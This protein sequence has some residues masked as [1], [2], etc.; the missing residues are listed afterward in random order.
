M[1]IG[2]VLGAGGVLGTA[3]LLGAL[4][5]V[6]AAT[7]WTPA[8]AE[9]VVGTSAGA[10]VGA[11]GATG[12]WPLPPGHSQ[13]ALLSSLEQASHY[14]LGAPR[15]PLIP[16]SARLLS[17]GWRAHPRSRSKLLAGILPQGLLLTQPVEAFISSLVPEGWP[18]RPRLWIV[19]TDYESGEPVVF[20]REDAPIVALP[21][22]VA[23]SCAMP[24]FFRP[25]HIEGRAYV[26]GAV[27]AGPGLGLLAGQGLDLA[28]CMNPGS[29]EIQGGSRLLRAVWH[30]VH[31][32]VAEQ[33]WTVEAKGTQVVIVEPSEAVVRRMGLNLM[34][35][36]GARQIGIQAA[37]DVERDVMAGPL[38]ASLSVNQGR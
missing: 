5:G 14:R 12:R 26:D 18:Q 19:A 32:Q 22:A 38:R 8:E 1:R 10:I 21:S 6:A 28:I 13:D 27:S 9:F 2:L 7:G 37:A 23:A 17:R 36:R 3:W 4:N 35:R 15:W 30:H 16:G 29:C 25:V 31:R 34:R 33:A 20:G 24:G 11:L